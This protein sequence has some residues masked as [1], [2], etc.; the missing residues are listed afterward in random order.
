MGDDGQSFHCA[1]FRL[2]SNSPNPSHPFDVLL[3]DRA[4]GTDAAGAEP[5]V[6]LQ[7]FQ[8]AVLG[9]LWMF[10]CGSVPYQTTLDRQPCR[11]C[12]ACDVISIH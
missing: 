12:L 10:G 2:G 5:T 6:A 8:V 4:W 9:A 1:G 3:R 7:C 11:L